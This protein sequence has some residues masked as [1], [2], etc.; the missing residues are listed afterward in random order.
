MLYT[1]FCNPRGLGPPMLAECTNLG[2]QTNTVFGCSCWRNGSFPNQVLFVLEMAQETDA[3]L[4][5][6]FNP[7][8]GRDASHPY[9]I[10]TWP[11]KGCTIVCVITEQVL[12]AAVHC[13]HYAF[14]SKSNKLAG[15][16]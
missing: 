11:K 13:M 12:K 16:R 3:I 9:L 10:R 8:L 4:T 6:L 5:N 15:G 2:T 1:F 7:T 14:L